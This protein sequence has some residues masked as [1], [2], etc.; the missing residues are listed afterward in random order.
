MRSDEER[1]L[2]A[3]R[4]MDSNAKVAALAAM[5]AWAK[6]RPQQEEPALRL[7]Y[8]QQSK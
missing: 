8:S 5:E 6:V 3:Y 2:A 1:I 7:V 4:V